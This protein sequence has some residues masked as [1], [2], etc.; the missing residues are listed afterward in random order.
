MKLDMSNIKPNLLNAAL[1]LGF[2]IL[3]IPAAKFLFVTKVH[4]PGLS[5]LIAAI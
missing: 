3:T 1:F 4:V 5:E 2:A